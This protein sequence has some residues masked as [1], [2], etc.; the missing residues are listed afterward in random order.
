LSTLQPLI[1]QH[2]KLKQSLNNLN[3][4]RSAQALE[5]DKYSAQWGLDVRYGN[6]QGERSDG[7]DLPDFM[8][9]MVTVDLPIFTEEKQDRHVASSKSK[10]HSARY[11]L[12]DTEREILKKLKQ[13]HA[14][15]V[16]FK[17]RLK[18][19]SKKI[20]SQAKQNTEVAMRGYQ[21]G[22]VDFLTLSKAQVT[23]FNTRLAELKLKYQ[24]SLSK[25]N[26][27]YLVGN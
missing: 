5:E 15:L 9:A 13:T 23:E 16:K 22:V 11:Q 4:Q 3:M 18:L 19:Y 2:P 26:L 7:S 10:V 27:E 21:S 14:R 12:I 25:S 8:T 17:Q 6:R 20:N 24:F 1:K